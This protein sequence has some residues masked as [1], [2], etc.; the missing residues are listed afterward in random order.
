MEKAKKFSHCTYEALLKVK[1]GVARRMKILRLIRRQRTPKAQESIYRYD[2]VS[3]LYRNAKIKN[4]GYRNERKKRKPETLVIRTLKEKIKE[5]N[6]MIERELGKRREKDKEA[7]EEIDA[8]VYR[9]SILE[10]ELYKLWTG[11]QHR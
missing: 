6:A 9:L 2:V 11:N 1:G 3:R 8:L 7:N 10:K 5:T 4:I